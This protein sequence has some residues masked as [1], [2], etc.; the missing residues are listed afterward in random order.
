MSIHGRGPPK[1]VGFLLVPIYKC[2][3][4][5]RPPFRKTR[6]Q[7]MLSIW[8]RAQEREPA[9]GIARRVIQLGTS[10]L[11]VSPSGCLFWSY[12]PMCVCLLLFLFLRKPKSKPLFWE[13]PE[14]RHTQIRLIS[15]AQ[16]GTMLAS[17]QPGNLVG[18]LTR[19]RPLHCFQWVT[20]RSWEISNDQNPRVDIDRYM[21]LWGNCFETNF[22]HYRSS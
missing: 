8:L 9:I 17:H 16:M 1:V 22:S 19:S 18:S 2:Q 21:R 12:Y 10:R 13:F 5:V 15:L 6:T 4:T 14:K 20:M 3:Q 7:P 11:Q